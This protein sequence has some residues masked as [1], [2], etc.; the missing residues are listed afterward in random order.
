MRIAV[1]SGTVGVALAIGAVAGLGMTPMARAE[2]PPNLQT[3]NVY[4]SSF[5]PSMMWD[6]SGVVVTLVNRDSIPHTIVLYR[7][8]LKTSFSATLQP[9]ER[10]T[11]SEPLTC[12]GTC[13]NAS[14][15]FADANTS[16]VS[17]GYCYS[18]CARLS[19]YNTGS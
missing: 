5:T 2:L 10:Y 3:I 14:Y 8:R 11:V 18:F 16:Y 13:G 15:A 9:G 7:Q 12:T 17:A 1:L 6:A 19:I 4:H